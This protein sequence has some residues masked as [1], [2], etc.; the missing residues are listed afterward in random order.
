MALYTQE[1][2]NYRVD[3]VAFSEARFYEKGQLEE[4]DSGYTFSWRGRPRTE[5]R[6][7]NVTFANRNDIESCLLQGINKRLLNP[8]SL[9]RSEFAPIMCAYA[10]RMTSSDETKNKFYE[11]FHD[12]LSSVPNADRLTVL[13]DFDARC[14]ERS[15]ASR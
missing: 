2:A 1:L 11:D 14:L 3:N 8:V 4:M 12:L 7:A 15:V 6:E 13:G 5:R 10:P 9:Q